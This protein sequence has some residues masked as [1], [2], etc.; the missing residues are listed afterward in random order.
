MISQRRSP[1]R[2]PSAQIIPSREP[3]ESVDLVLK[4]ANGW[5]FLVIVWFSF[6]NGVD[7]SLP[8]FLIGLI[9]AAA[10]IRRKEEAQLA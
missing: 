10:G 1:K 8:W 3:D 4:S 9:V 7:L 5:L 2:R 6:G